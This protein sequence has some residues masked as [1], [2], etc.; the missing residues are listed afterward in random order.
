VA[1]HG[2]GDDDDRRAAGVEGTSTVVPRGR[3]DAKSWPSALTAWKPKARSL[4]R[5][6]EREHLLGAADG[7]DPVSIDHP[8]HVGQPVMAMKSAASNAP[9]VELAVGSDAEEAPILAFKRAPSA[10]P[11]ERRGRSP[12]CPWRR[13]LRDAAG[14]R[15]GREERPLLVER[16]DLAGGEASRLGQQGV[17][18]GRRLALGEDEG[19]RFPHPGE[20][21]EHQELGAGEGA[22]DVAGVGAV[23]HGEEAPLHR[24]DALLQHHPLGRRGMWHHGAGPSLPRLPDARP[25]YRTRRR[26]AMPR[27][28]L[29][30]RAALLAVARFDDVRVDRLVRRVGRVAR[31]DGALVEGAL[32]R[33]VVAVAAV[34][35]APRMM[36]PACASAASTRGA[37]RPTWWSGWAGSRPRPSARRS[38]CRCSSPSR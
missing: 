15:Q 38:T 31:D 4:A 16:L 34:P 27:S 12:G 35:P 10:I 11:A 21:Q 18:R 33:V 6:L 32:A 9:L 23:D 25:D 8:D 1:L 14:G 36:A 13:D 30:A 5:R 26:P 3:S 19:V 29:G 20:A 2:A 17:E 24:E 37:R 28:R 7:L 22:A